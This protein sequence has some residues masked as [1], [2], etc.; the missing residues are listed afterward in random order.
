VNPLV[1]VSVKDSATPPQPGP[2]G[3][4][5]QIKLEDLRKRKIFL[6]VPM[7]AGISHGIFVRSAIELSSQCAQLG[8]ALQI[9]FLFNESL[10][11]RARNY[12]VDEFMNSDC[13]HLMFI[14]SDIGFNPR[15]TSWLCSEPLGRPRTHRT[16]SSAART[17]R[18]PSRGRRSR[19]LSTRAWPTRPA[20]TSRSFVGDYVFNPK[21]APIASHS[22]SRAR[23]S[24]S[25]PAS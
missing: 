21:P 23:S 3:I 18:R 9:Y 12:C 2:L 8:I 15:R 6:A 7:Y 11:T 13:T 22:A 25:A 1:T 16:T 5:F 10:I 4:N 17:R 20:R 19:S 14:D 24:R